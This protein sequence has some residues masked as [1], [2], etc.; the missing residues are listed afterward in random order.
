MDASFVKLGKV[1]SMRGWMHKGET[2]ASGGTHHVNGNTS[3]KVY[4]STKCIFYNIF[5]S[6]TKW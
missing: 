2:Q 3:S 1:K 6:I 4:N 5:M